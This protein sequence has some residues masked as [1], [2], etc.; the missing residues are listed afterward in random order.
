MA[1]VMIF[2]PLMM[3]AIAAA[4]PSNRLRPWLLPLTATTYMA[5]VV[6]VLMRPELMFTTQWLI[7]DPPARIVLLVVSTLFL[8]CSLY[9]VGY[10]QY[11]KERS[12]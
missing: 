12:N 6:F 4:I 5:M 9:S 10:L 2:F 11:R 3:A 1:F 8:F 7:L